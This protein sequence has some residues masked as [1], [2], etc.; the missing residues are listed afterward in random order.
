VIY[1]LFV[2]PT[3]ELPDLSSIQVYYYASCSGVEIINNSTGTASNS[4]SDLAMGTTGI[5]LLTVF[6]GVG[7]GIVVLATYFYCFRGISKDGLSD[8]LTGAGL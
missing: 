7:A 6:L 1:C 8:G 3:D 4:S 5:V 2:Y